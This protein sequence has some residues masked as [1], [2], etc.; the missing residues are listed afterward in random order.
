M[1]QVNLNSKYLDNGEE[2]EVIKY[3]NNMTMEFSL[4]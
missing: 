4:F 2:H 1:Y 3:L